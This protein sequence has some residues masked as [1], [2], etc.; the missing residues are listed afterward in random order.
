MSMKLTSTAFAHE[1]SMPSRFTCDGTNI[2]PPLAWSGAPAGTKSFALVV[3]DPDA[4]DPKAPK[5]TWVHWVVYNLPAD[6][7]GLREAIPSK[8]LPAGTLDGTSDFGE[9]GYG[10][11]CPPVGRHRYI[12]T[13]YALDAVLADLGKPTRAKLLGAMQSHV[14]ATAELIGTYQRP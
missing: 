6:A 5:M 12:H 8:E 3:T 9:T 11:P 2:S 14:L 4:P 1:A 10:G 7:A 13:L